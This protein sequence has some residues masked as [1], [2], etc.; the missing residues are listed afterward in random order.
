MPRRGEAFDGADLGDDQQREVE[1]E[2]MDA[3][4]HPDAVVMTGALVDL[5]GKPSISRSNSVIRR[6]ST[7]RR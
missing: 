4:E 7:S 3:A 2:A 6:R 5:G 1:P